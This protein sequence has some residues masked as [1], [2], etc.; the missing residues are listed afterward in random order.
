[1]HIFVLM[2]TKQPSPPTLS[3][4]MAVINSAVPRAMDACCLSRKRLVAIPVGTNSLRRQSTAYPQNIDMIRVPHVWWKDQIN[5][6]RPCQ[7]GLLS[8]PLASSAGGESDRGQDS[9]RNGYRT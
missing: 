4:V 7:T 8:A 6:S 5:A 2:K 9:S 3:P 1:M